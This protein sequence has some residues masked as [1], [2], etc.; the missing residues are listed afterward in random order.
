MKAKGAEAIN[1][2]HARLTGMTGKEMSAALKKWLHQR[3]NIL[4]QLKA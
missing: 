3:I 1:A 4:V 2:Q